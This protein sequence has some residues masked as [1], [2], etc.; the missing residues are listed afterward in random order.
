M[1]TP[2]IIGLSA[3]L[4]SILTL[5]VYLIE[6]GRDVT[7]LLVV[8]AAVIPSLTALFGV[9]KV[10]K[11]TNGT[12]TALRVE[13]AQLRSQLP[14]YIATNVPVQDGGGGGAISLTP[15]VAPSTN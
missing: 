11:Q 3:T 1:K 6:T 12:N 8:L 5:V 14:A 15:G 13:N 9:D 10:Q 2:I 4:V 7:P